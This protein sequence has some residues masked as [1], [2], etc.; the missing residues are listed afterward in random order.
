MAHVDTA[1]RGARKVALASLVGTTVEWYDFF[2]YGTAAALVFG[3]LV[4]PKYGAAVGTLAALATFGVGFVARPV[5]GALFGH[6]GD[7]VGRKATLVTTLMLMGASTLA[8]GLLPTYDHI[9]VLAPVALV[10]LR[11]LQGLAVGGEWGG[12][13]LMATEHAPAHRRGFYGSWPQM[14]VPLGLILATS[15][16]AV[17]TDQMAPA[18]FASW[19]WR[20]PF[21]FSAV[22]IVVGLVVRMKVAESPRFAEL[23]REDNRAEAPVLEVLRHAKLRTLLVVGAQTAVN[24]GFYVITVYALSYATATVGMSRTTTLI[25]LI[26]GAVADLA[27]LPLFAALSDKVGRRPVLIAGCAFLGLFAYPFFLLINS[28]S[29]VLL[30]LAVV[31]NMVLGHAPCYAVISSFIAETYDT[32]SRYSGSSIAY[33]LA[34]ATSSGPTPIIAGALVAAYGGFVPVVVMLVVAAIIAIVCVLALQ[35][36]RTVDLAH[37]ER[38]VD[39]RA[40]EHDVELTGTRPLTS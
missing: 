17:L 10:V 27:V 11:L 7:R 15:I 33:H 34:G 9:G 14:G 31:A 18:A 21:L 23:V 32:S 16:F 3:Q 40:E 8:V 26:I 2:V 35:E 30:T 39:P 24:V 1:G 13:V 20:I 25:A 19:G 4:F 36:T 38:S 37:R 28:G 12:A 29:G 6:Y 5:G 22:L